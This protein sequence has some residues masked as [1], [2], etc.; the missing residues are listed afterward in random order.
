MSQTAAAYRETALRKAEQLR[1]KLRKEV[2]KIQQ[3]DDVRNK[4]SL[5]DKLIVRLLPKFAPPTTTT[6]TNHHR[7]AKRRPTSPSDTSNA[8]VIKQQ[9]L[10]KLQK[11]QKQLKRDREA[12]MRS[13]R[14]LAVELAG[15]ETRCPVQ[16]LLLKCAVVVVQ[17]MLAHVTEEQKL[18]QQR[19]TRMIMCMTPEHRSRQRVLEVAYE[20]QAYALAMKEGCG[21]GRFDDV[22]DEDETLPLP[23]VDEIDKHGR[24]TFDDLC[25]M[26]PILAHSDP[27]EIGREIKKLEAQK[28]ILRDH[29]P[30]SDAPHLNALPLTAAIPT[31]YMYGGRPGMRLWLERTVPKVNDNK[32]FLRALDEEGVVSL[33]GLM[34]VPVEKLEQMVAIGLNVKKK[35]TKRRQNELSKAVSG[36]RIGMRGDYGLLRRCVTFRFSKRTGAVLYRMVLRGLSEANSTTPG[37]NSYC[38]GCRYGLVAHAW[39][40]GQSQLELLTQRLHIVQEQRAHR[41]LPRSD[42]GDI[43]TELSWYQAL[44]LR[45]HLDRGW[46]YGANP[47]DVVVPT[48][49]A[50]KRERNKTES[51]L[52]GMSK[53][54][55]HAAEWE[56]FKQ[57]RRLLTGRRNF[58]DLCDGEPR[59]EPREEGGGRQGRATR[60]LKLQPLPTRFAVYV[61]PDTATMALG[62]R[63][64]VGRGEHRGG[65]FMGT[66]KCDQTERRLLP[67][68][69]EFQM[70]QTPLRLLS[71]RTDPL[72]EYLR[73]RHSSGE[74]GVGGRSS[75]PTIDADDDV[76]IGGASDQLGSRSVVQLEFSGL[77]VIGEFEEKRTKSRSFGFIQG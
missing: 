72:L 44:R 12:A 26:F 64:G 19:N 76:V 9:K 49:T 46:G 2:I 61:K 74:R 6:T 35:G 29:G 51:K 34:K 15:L 41:P 32:Q 71:K 27:Q 25:S 1:K 60:S 22:E 23:L 77:D 70:E 52:L 66:N 75:R 36:L 50:S 33:Q 65:L 11:Q 20:K 5:P 68:T 14:R 38:S 67:P 17:D 42:D 30:K 63:K 56:N 7:A 37:K 48:S 21:K 4:Y 73:R 62:G 31:E 59:G 16:L 45:L 55:E 47:R 54:A 3:E 40:C 18:E 69:F 58:V 43:A 57:R 53:A 8:E 10:Q 28:L 39:D 13:G 24:F